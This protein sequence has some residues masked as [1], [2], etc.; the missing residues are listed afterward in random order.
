MLGRTNDPNIVCIFRSTITHHSPSL[1][2][3]Q[4]EKRADK[5]E[6]AVANRR[7]TISKL[8]GGFR[9]LLWMYCW[10]FLFVYSS[11]F[12]PRGAP[13][14]PRGTHYDQRLYESDPVWP[15]RPLIFSLL[16]SAAWGHHWLLPLSNIPLSFV[17]LGTSSLLLPLR[18][19]YEGRLT[20]SL[21]ANYFN[22]SKRFVF[23]A[24]LWAKLMIYFE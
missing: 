16:P 6:D 5:A 4:A 21:R 19:H 3:F 2:L 9:L 22:L 14:G 18:R 10:S 11:L 20:P 7:A 13:Q 15:Q 17:T 23:F 12:P 24:C 1:L 8:E